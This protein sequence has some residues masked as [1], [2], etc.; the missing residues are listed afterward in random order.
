V[1]FLLFLLF[2][3]TSSAPSQSTTPSA[4]PHLIIQTV[5]AA[6][7]ALSGATVAVKP[8]DGKTQSISARTDEDGFAKFSVPVD[9]EYSVEISAMY[10]RST[11]LKRLRLYKPSGASQ[12]A[13]IQITLE[14]GGTEAHSPRSTR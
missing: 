7:F 6:H 10:F 12:T 3:Q 11:T 2:L 1:W 13:Y 5:D 9:A 8:L 14:V 4:A